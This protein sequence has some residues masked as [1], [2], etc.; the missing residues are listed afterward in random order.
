MITLEQIKDLEDKIHKA[1]VAL[2]KSRRENEELKREV[3][4]QNSKIKELSA[5]LDQYRSE[6]SEIEQGIISALEH[7]DS[8]EDAVSGV[9]ATK[10]A[11]VPE[12]E[13]NIYENDSL[14]ESAAEQIEISEI[15]EDETSGV[16]SE[17][18]RESEDFELSEETIDQTID[19]DYEEEMELVTPEAVILLEI[20][21]DE[22]EANTTTEE[23]NDEMVYVNAE[24][25][26]EI[27]IDD[28]LETAASLE[29]DKTTTMTEENISEEPVEIN[30]DDDYDDYDD[31]EGQL[32]I[33]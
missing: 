11:A 30:L 31:E 32:D 9:N 6:Q 27:E 28:D 18:A 20:E 29:P 25:T 24:E 3:G 16:E 5:I 8:L 15:D 19:E 4:L 2:D 14:E 12:T 33:F 7:L 23:S 10:P 1:V 21:D 17:I 22:A 26:I 13:E